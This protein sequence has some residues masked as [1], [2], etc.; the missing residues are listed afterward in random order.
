M[1][2]ESDLEK[3]W[4]LLL[5]QG[6]IAQ[7][8]CSRGKTAKDPFA[9]FFFYF[10]AF[11][12]LYFLWTNV[13]DLRNEA[14][15]RPNEGTQ[16][17]HLLTKM[18]E[19]EAEVIISALQNQIRYFCRRGPIQR[20]DKRSEDNH[21]EGE[22]KEGKKWLR[23]LCDGTTAIGRLVALGQILY[24]VRS[25]LVHGSKAESGDDEE[26]ISNAASMLEIILERVLP[27]TQKRQ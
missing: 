16:I 6:N 23:Q 27:F 10:T 1:G 11:N 26:I 21:R 7:R 3:W 15:K 18:G 24:L 14:G 17:A 2:S 13:D 5:F 12:A 20:M 8:W 22:E 25:N 4:E 9:K 19:Q